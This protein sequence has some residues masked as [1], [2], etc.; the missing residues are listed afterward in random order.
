MIPYLFDPCF[1][2]VTLNLLVLFS[3]SHQKPGDITLNGI[4]FNLLS[5]T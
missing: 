2:P 4:I 3:V 1:V 5:G